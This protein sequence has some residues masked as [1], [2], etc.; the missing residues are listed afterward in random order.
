[1]IAANQRDI[2]RVAYFER[3]EQEERLHTIEATVNK[4][5]HEEVIRP[6]TVISHAE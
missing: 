6:R 2:S 1:M 4:I 5:A 3:Q